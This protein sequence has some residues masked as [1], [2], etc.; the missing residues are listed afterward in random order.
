MIA[1]FENKRLALL[2]R[3]RDIDNT[4]DEPMVKCVQSC[5]AATKIF[6]EV[7]E[8]IKQTP[9]KDKCQEIYFLKSCCPFFISEIIYHQQLSVHIQ[10]RM[11]MK[12][13]KKYKEFCKQQIKLNQRH[14]DNYGEFIAYHSS[15]L[16]NRD[17]EYVLSPLSSLYLPIDD[18]CIIL[19]RDYITDYPIIIGRYIASI[20]ISQ[21]L[22]NDYKSL[23]FEPFFPEVFP[24]REND[25]VMSWT[26]S[27]V[28]AVELINALVSTRCIN[29]GN[30][31][32]KQVINHFET[33][34]NT[35]IGNYYDIF[36]EIK[37]RKN[38]TQFLDK[39]K[40]SLIQKVSED[41]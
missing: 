24:T 20:R 41:G 9:F 8:H 34:F 12:S 22:T 30:C 37:A 36:S 1:T 6:L 32:I 33:C 40:F 4:T 38:P 17:E 5:N 10:N 29:N 39:I 18:T 21:H 16:T 27:K 7:I 15:G 23:K 31:S 2:E 35:K 19:N 11:S 13:P 26:E 14:I 25:A 3:F 28:A